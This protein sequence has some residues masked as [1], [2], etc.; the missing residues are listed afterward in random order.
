MQVDE[1]HV[2]ESDHRQS[3][4]GSS[5]RDRKLLAPPQVRGVKPGAEMRDR[6]VTPSQADAAA[7][8]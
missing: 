3:Q 8:Q 1:Y 7:Q 2:L 5:R 6:P 4:D